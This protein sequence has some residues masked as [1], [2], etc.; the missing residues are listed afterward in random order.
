[1][2]SGLKIL[3]LAE[4]LAA[5]SATRQGLV[6]QNIAHADTPGYR[7]RDLIPFSESMAARA[8]M[9]DGGFRPAATRPGH[10]AGMA[11]GEARPREDARIGSASPNGNTVSL[12]DQMVRSADLRMQ[13]EMALGVYRK[14]MEILRVSLTA[15]R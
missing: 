14:S 4:A 8:A 12:E 1:M 15:P 2:S 7:A 11:L 13:H 3:S 5:Y 6:A 10:A 9:D